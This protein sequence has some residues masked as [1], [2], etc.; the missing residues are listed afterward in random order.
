MSARFSFSSEQEDLRQE[1]RRFLEEQAPMASVR[2]WME[3][4]A[5]FDREL[6]AR[7][8]GELGL[9]G[10]HIPEA[11]A[12]QGLGFVEL[13]IVLEEL[14]RSLVGTPYLASVGMAASA[15]LELGSEA[16]KKALL[17][18][19][20]SGECIATLAWAERSGSPAEAGVWDGSRSGLRAT[21]EPDGHY[22]LEGTKSYVL[23]GEAA[24]L[25]VVLAEVTR[26]AAPA[27]RALFVLPATSAG[28]A[29]SPQASI[30]PTRRLARIEFSN[31]RAELLSTTENPAAGLA[32]SFSRVSVALACEM[33]GGAERALEMAVAYAKERV[34]FGRP[35]GSFQAI[36]HK[37]ADLLLELEPSR[38]ASYYAAA[39]AAEDGVELGAVAALAKAM[40]SDAYPW[41]AAENIQVHG[42]VGFTWEYDAQLYYKRALFCQAFWGDA[43]LHRERYL[44][45]R[46]LG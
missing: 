26:H 43:R 30:D 15:I 3:T 39:V 40:L 11:Y 13:C 5:G 36:K 24:D 6:W 8:A 46:G 23:D 37:L 20:A 4:P 42:G 27:S 7:L 41:I 38:S 16:Q 19:I 31:A 33:V 9:A 45:E 18:G 34:Q 10:V 29:R 21:P 12:G 35:I 22:R 44:H 2:R 25:L 14:G 32:R 28:V 1:V 17:P